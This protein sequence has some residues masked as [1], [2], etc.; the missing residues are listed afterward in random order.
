[1]NVNIMSNGQLT[2]L[3]NGLVVPE[4]RHYEKVWDCSNVYCVHIEC[5][6][7]ILFPTGEAN[8]VK[9]EYFNE[10]RRGEW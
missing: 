8:K 9:E 7:C 4:M 3:F 6:D 2:K 1:M 10:L 5:K